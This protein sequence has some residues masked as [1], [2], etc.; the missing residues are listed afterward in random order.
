MTEKSIPAALRALDVAPPAAKTGYPAPFA[1]LVAGRERRRLGEQF[2]LTNYGVNLVKLSPGAV[3]A[4]RHAHSA[5]DEFV[6]IV[7]GTPT[8]LTNDGATALG[9]GMCAGFK[10]GNG[11]AH[12][13]RN[14]SSDEVWYIEVGART[15]GDEVVY[16]DDDLALQTV[17]GRFV[18][19]HKDGTPYPAA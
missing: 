7:Q 13:L 17:D 1:A 4:M 15:P 8:L 19:T 12:Q 3:S 10:A 11:D 14:D 2:G 18:Y 6:Y 9:P 5:E 16:P